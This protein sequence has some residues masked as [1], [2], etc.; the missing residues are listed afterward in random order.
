MDLDV[1]MMGMNVLRIIAV[2]VTVLIMEHSEKGF[3]AKTMAMTAQMISVKMEIVPTSTS[4]MTKTHVL[5]I[6]AFTMQIG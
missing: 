3:L 2:M 6:F 4:A 1:L 5:L